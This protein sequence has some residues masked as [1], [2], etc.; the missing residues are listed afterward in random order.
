MWTVKVLFSHQNKSKSTLFLPKQKQNYSF[1]A[2]I[3][4]KAKT[5][6]TYVDTDPFL[7]WWQGPPCT[8]S[9]VSNLISLTDGTTFGC[10]WGSVS[11]QRTLWNVNRWSSNYL[12]FIGSSYRRP[13]WVF[14]LQK[15]DTKNVNWI[16]FMLSE[17]HRFILKVQFNQ[18]VVRN[19][20]QAKWGPGN[21]NPFF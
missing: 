5:T 3:K 21:S 15:C 17:Q 7:H 11:W 20:T 19:G 13:F 4:A 12:Y 1:L 9:S 14:C 10:L 8:C 6:A 18:N 16:K 2:K